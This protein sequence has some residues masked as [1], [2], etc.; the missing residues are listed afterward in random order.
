MLA[1]KD[2]KFLEILTFEK[3]NG[4]T[5]VL[6]PKIAIALFFSYLEHCESSS[7]GFGW[8][9]FKHPNPRFSQLSM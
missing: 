7:S 8:G 3:G 9:K 4:A 1:S 2:I 5:A 6:A